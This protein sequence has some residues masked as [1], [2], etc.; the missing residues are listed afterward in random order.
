MAIK[1]CVAGR[2]PALGSGNGPN[3][4]TRHRTGKREIQFKVAQTCERL[5]N[6]NIRH[7]CFPFTGED[8]LPYLDHGNKQWS[9]EFEF[10][11]SLVLGANFGKRDPGGFARTVFWKRRQW[12]SGTPP[13]PAKRHRDENPP[14]QVRLAAQHRS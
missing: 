9:Y 4:K 1:I 14:A 12:V 7:V 11:F 3:P 2:F 13:L 10:S 8:F 6:T 5:S